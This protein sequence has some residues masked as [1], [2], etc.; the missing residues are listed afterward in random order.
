L[1]HLDLED[2][3]DVTDDLLFHGNFSYE[4]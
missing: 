4:F 1:I 3:S 2:L